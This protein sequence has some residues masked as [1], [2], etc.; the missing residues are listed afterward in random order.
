MADTASN[1]IG[2]YRRKLFLR[3]AVETAVDDV[4]APRIRCAYPGDQR[5][6]VA[7]LEVKQET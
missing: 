3:V 4:Y 7:L 5:V 2:L 1:A 6:K